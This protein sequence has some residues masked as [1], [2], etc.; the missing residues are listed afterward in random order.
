MELVGEAWG[1]SE[2]GLGEPWE[3]G[4]LGNKRPRGVAA[5]YRVAK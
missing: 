1:E 3:P 5:L 2:R 4:G